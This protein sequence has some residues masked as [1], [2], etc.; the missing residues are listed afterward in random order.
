[1][2]RSKSSALLHRPLKARS[3]SS[4]NRASSWVLNGLFAFLEVSTKDIFP[5]GT[6]EEVDGRSICILHDGSQLGTHFARQGSQNAN[7]IETIWHFLD[8]PCLHFS[9]VAKHTGTHPHG[10]CGKRFSSAFGCATASTTTRAF[11]RSSSGMETRA[12]R[13]QR[14]H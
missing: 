11:T 9:A 14:L 2:G 13:F 10:R 8:S 12:I 1:M 3:K 7:P 6:P 5:S 4:L